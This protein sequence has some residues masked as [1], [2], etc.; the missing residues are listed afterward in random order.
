MS[1][2]YADE[3]VTARYVITLDAPS[4]DWPTILAQAQS[5]TTSGSTYAPPQRGELWPTNSDYGLYAK[6]F[7]MRL[8]DPEKSLKRILLDVSYLPLDPGEPD[9]G[10]SPDNPLFWPAEYD[11]QYA[12]EEFVVEQARNVEA[13]TGAGG[14]GRPAG[15]LGPVTNSAGRRNRGAACRRGTGGGGQDR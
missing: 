10:N 7:T 5:L 6:R 3:S 14:Y 13:F 8:E 12:E 1:N 15:T 2:R 11:I 4:D 9:P